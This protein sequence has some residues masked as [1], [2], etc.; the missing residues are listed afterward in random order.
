MTREQELK[1]YTVSSEII[2]TAKKLNAMY[3][4]LLSVMRDCE[5]VTGVS[6]EEFKPWLDNT[7]AKLNDAWNRQ[8]D[9]LLEGKSKEVVHSIAVDIAKDTLK[10]LFEDD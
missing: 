2:D 4:A 8:Y 5:S 9:A 7:L 6:Y 1:C 10:E 3:N